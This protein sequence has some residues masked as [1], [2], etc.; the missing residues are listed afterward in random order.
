MKRR[1]LLKSGTLLGAAAGLGVSRNGHTEDAM[2]CTTEQSRNASLTG[3]AG[4]RSCIQTPALILDLDIMERNLAAMAQRCESD[5]LALRPHCKTHKSVRVAERQIAHGAI[6]VCTATV[7]EAEALISGGITDILI[8]RPVV[9]AEQISWLLELGG[10]APELRVVA[11]NPE[12]LVALEQA[13][14]THARQLR[15]VV[16]VDVSDRRTGCAG[17]DSAIRLAT[18]IDQSEMLKFSGIQAYSG[19]AQHIINADE[20]RRAVTDTNSIVSE[21]LTGLA[22]NGLEPEIVSG[23]GT[24]TFD[25]LTISGVFTELQAGSYLL[26]DRQYNEV[27]TEDSKRPP[28]E[29]ALFVQTVVISNNHDGFVTTDAGQKRFAMDAGKPEIASGAPD[30]ASYST[31][32]D[33]HGFVRFDSDSD[34]LELGSRIE[35]IVPHCDPTVNLYYAYHCVRG[36][37]LV[38]IWRID[39]RG[40]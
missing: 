1:S 16:D 22:A 3:Q 13:A 32:G 2:N 38:D 15:V 6:G 30:R 8:T 17:V 18:L 37:T 35:C 40:A 7:G 11:D 31:A 33:E 24:G 5:G 26:M 23:G 9:T 21:V 10:N 12:N 14:S 27:W 34:R 36:D 20:R 29:T 19:R 39:A 4:S 28:F 25:L